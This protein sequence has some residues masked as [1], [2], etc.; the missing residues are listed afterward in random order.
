MYRN[1][2][3]TFA[4]TESPGL[5]SSG[6]TQRHFFCRQKWK[7]NDKSWGTW[8]HSWGE[9]PG[10]RPEQSLNSQHQELSEGTTDIKSQSKTAAGSSF[11]K[12]QNSVYSVELVFSY[13]WASISV[14]LNL[15][16]TG[17]FIPG[18]GPICFQVNG[19]REQAILKRTDHIFSIQEYY[20]NTR[21]TWTDGVSLVLTSL[22]IC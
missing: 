21:M 14:K 22:L 15:T 11:C 5:R 8:D 13:E 2:Q 19:W 9:P 1:I 17:N 16:K 4:L 7:K 18:V 3:D 6:H 12:L 10:K 20:E